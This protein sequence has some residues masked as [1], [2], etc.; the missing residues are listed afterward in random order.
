MKLTEVMAQM[1]LTDIYRTL[2]PISKEYDFFQH[3]IVPYPT[4]TIQS[5]TKLTSTDTKLK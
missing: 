1:D 2:H 3:L 5:V 4:L